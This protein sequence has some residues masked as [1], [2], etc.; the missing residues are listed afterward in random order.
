MVQFDLAV[1]R[2]D[3][4][5]HETETALKEIDRQELAIATIERRIHK[6]LCDVQQLRK[7]QAEH[8]GGL[9]DT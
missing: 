6:L 9:F 7:S 1:F 2:R 4:T 3:P 8:L 5:P